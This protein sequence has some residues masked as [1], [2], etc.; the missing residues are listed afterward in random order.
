V[1]RETPEK[2]KRRRKLCDR[3]REILGTLLSTSRREDARRDATR[4]VLPAPLRPTIRVRGLGNT[5]AWSFSGLKLR[6]PFIRSFS[7]LH[8]VARAQI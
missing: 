8:M 2:K 5:I 6:M 7:T 4:T 3:E 1:N